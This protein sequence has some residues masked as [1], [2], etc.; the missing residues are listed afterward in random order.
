MNALK[1]KEKIVYMILIMTLIVDAINGFI[2]YTFNIEYSLIGMIYRGLII[3]YFGIYFMLNSKKN[4]TKSIYIIIFLAINMAVSYFMYT[5]SLNSLSKNFI[6]ELKNIL[7]III[8]V[9]LVDMIKRKKLRRELLT[10]I[11]YD[12]TKIVLIIYIFSI[13]FTNFGST[14]ST[15]GYKAIF[16]SNN[17]LNIVLIILFIFQMEKFLKY[18]NYRDIFYTLFLIIVLILLG[19]KSSIMF[20]IYYFIMK[21]LLQKNVFKRFKIICFLLVIG[22]ILLKLLDIFFYEQ[23]QQ[24][25]ERQMYFINKV[26][27]D[28]SIFTYLVSNR[29]DFLS[30]AILDFKSNFSIIRL[31]FGTG[32]FYNQLVVGSQL[33]VELKSIE[34][35]LFDIFFSYG[36]IGI[37]ITYGFAIYILIKNYKQIRQD[38]YHAELIS[39]LSIIIFSIL[40]G[41]VF[42]EAMSSIYFGIVLA[43]ISTTMYAEDYYT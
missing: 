15:A 37:V 29:N 22:I 33:G 32:A 3:C 25:V 24:I 21:L 42:N 4:F 30:S 5:S 28:N 27:L 41:H 18:K 43:L 11:I 16:Y 12:S 7:F 9:S 19:S 39:L 38:A 10:K 40:G 8:S 17:A 35:D 6:D 31:L 36:F 13:C 2:I 1:N 20:I 26:G 14:Y 23:I 34:M